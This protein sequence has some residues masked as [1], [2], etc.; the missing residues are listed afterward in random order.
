[1]ERSYPRSVRIVAG[2]R[3]RAQPRIMPAKDP[4]RRRATMRAWYAR[5]KHVRRTS[6]LVEL[7]RQTKQARRHDIAE[8]FV[9]LKSVLVCARCGEDHPGCLQFHH[10]DPSKKEIGVSDAV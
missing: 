10:A 9:S 2:Q 8:W 5:T 7:E 4:E 3:W 6:E 1:T